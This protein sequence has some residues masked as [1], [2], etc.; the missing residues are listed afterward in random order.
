MEIILI[1]SSVD[2]HGQACGILP[3]GLIKQY[4][5]L[6]CICR[7][8]SI[9]LNKLLYKIKTLKRNLNNIIVALTRLKVL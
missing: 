3:F 7:K 6:K 9:L 5:E 8:F 4:T 2:T 1:K